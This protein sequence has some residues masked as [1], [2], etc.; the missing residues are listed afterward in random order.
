MAVPGIGVDCIH[1]VL[2]VLV[3]AGIIDRPTLPAYDER[4]G[5]L[6][7]R[8]VIEDILTAHLHARPAEAPEFGDIVVCRCGRQSNHIGIVIDDQMWHSPG[9]GYCGPEALANWRERI[10]SFV[11]IEQTGLRADP[12]EL[13]ARGILS[14]APPGPTA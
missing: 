4:L 6:R 13:T 3:E 5:A 12:A 2:A 10:Q 1:F 14:F 8:N 9:K 7:E 11:R